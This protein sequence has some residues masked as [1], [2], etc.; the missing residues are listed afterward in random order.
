MFVLDTPAI[1]EQITVYH[2]YKG[3]KTRE[4]HSFEYHLA[5]YVNI[6]VHIRILTDVQR[7]L[8]VVA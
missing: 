1:Q 2:N 8:I 3:I 5:V 7:D 6:T 4:S